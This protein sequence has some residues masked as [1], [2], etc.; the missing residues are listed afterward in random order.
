MF[1]VCVVEK[2]VTAHCWLLP[3]VKRERTGVLGGKVFDLNIIC[4]TPGGL[5]SAR[6]CL[7][8][9]FLMP[10]ERD[11]QRPH[12]SP[13]MQDCALSTNSWYLLKRADLKPQLANCINK[14]ILSEA[15][16]QFVYV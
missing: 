12:Q 16:F 2:P 9:R 15:L 8:H 3:K 4:G 5:H 1:T 10:G 14:H 7:P 13:A 6:G 11:F